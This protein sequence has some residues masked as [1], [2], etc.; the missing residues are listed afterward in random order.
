[1]SPSCIDLFL[2]NCPKS[3]ESTLSIE[4]GLSDFYK[5]IVTILKVKRENIPPKIIQY[6]R[7]KNFG[8][9]RF[10]EKLPLRHTHF[11]MNSLDSGSLKKC[12]MELLNKVPSLKTKFLRAN[13]SKFVTKDVSKA[14]MLR[15]KLRNQFLKKRTLEARMKYNKQKSICVSLI[16]K[17]ERN[18]YDNLDLKDINDNKRYWAT[19]K[20][21]FLRK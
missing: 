2:K 9:T 6:R 4:T 17:D 10:Y 12:F 19:V 3:F 1:M 16:K 18:Y 8:L 13:H 11:D 20:P 7:Y 5:L 14:I 21:L 15:T